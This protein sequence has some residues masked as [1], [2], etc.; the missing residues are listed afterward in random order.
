MKK[1]YFPGV[2]FLIFSSTLTVWAQ[3]PMQ[4]QMKQPVVCYHT[5]EPHMIDVPPPEVYLQWKKNSGARTAANATFEVEY[6]GFDNAPEA[7]AAFDRAFEIWSQ[8]ISSPVPIRVQAEWASLGSNVLGSAIYTSA[9][10]NFDGAQKLNVFYPIALAEKITGLELNDGEPDIFTRFSS[11]TNWNFDPNA[12]PAPDEFDL[13]SVVLHEIGHGLG[14]AGTFSKSGTI[15]EYGLSTTSVPIIFDVP[16]ENGSDVNLI[17]GFANPSASLGTQITGSSLFFDAQLSGTSRLYAPATYSS[18]SSISHLNESTYTTGGD[19]LMTPQIAPGERIHDPGRALSMLKDLGWETIVIEHDRLP[20]TETVSG[21]FPVTVTIRDDSGYDD[22]KISYST[23]DGESFTTVAMTATGNPDE[24]TF[25]IPATGNPTFYRYY[26]TV[27]NGDATYTN[28]GKFVVPQD[29]EI[30][31]SFRFQAGPD[32]ESPVI[33]HSPKAFLLTT[34]SQLELEA[35][36]TDNIEVAS[37]TVAYSINDAAQTPLALSL[38]NPGEDSVYSVTLN[39]GALEEGDV[40]EY[41]IIARDNASAGFNERVSDVFEVNIVGLKETQDSY[42][43][44]FDAVG[45]SDDFFGTGFS[46]TTPAGFNSAAIHSTHP[47]LAGEAFEGDSLVTTYQLKVPIR[48]R[49]TD[50]LIKFEEI[51]LVEPGESGSSFGDPDFYDYVVVEGSLDGGITWEPVANGYDSRA[52]SV[53]FTRFNSA[54]T[55]GSSTATGDPTLYKARQLNLL[56]KYDAGDVVVLRFKLYSDQLATGWGWAIDNL[57][58]QVDETNPVVYNDHVDY[59]LTGAEQLA[60]VTAAE[61]AGG[62][63]SLKVEYRVN[64]GT[65]AE[66]A[67]DVDPPASTYTLNIGLDGFETGDLIEYRIVATDSADLN[68]TF[69]PDGSFIKVPIIEFQSAVSTYTNNFN[70]ATSDFVGNFYSIAQPSGFSNGAI[71]STHNYPVGLGIEK[72]S[73][74]TYTLLKPITIA[75]ANSYIRFDEIAIVETQSASIPFGSPSF[76]DYVIVEGSTDGGET[77]LPF[78]DGYDALRQSNWVSAFTNK[79]DGTSS[80]YRSRAFDMTANGNFDAGDDVIIRFRLFSNTTSAGWGWT[81]DNL[82]IQDFV[83]DAETSLDKAISIHPNPTAE[84]IIINTTGLSSGPVSVQLMN[85]QGNRLQE[86]LYQGNLE[87]E[88][89]SL[90]DLPGGVYF[91]R[92]ASD[93]RTVVRKVVKIN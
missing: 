26:I 88:E 91:V 86:R 56:N 30:Q 22:V 3:K 28:P 50:A 51:V 24:Y 61:D 49:E 52:Q 64:G 16:I 5:N 66:T 20:N 32:T 13:V 74:F 75:A 72:T 93:N 81:I 71:H 6:I 29:D 9:F 77:W 87:N 62:I 31:G 41:T 25:N 23:N 60:I 78:L 14:F 55:D 4:I 69:P 8:L 33:T 7:K 10:A 58:I 73:D 38:Q 79:T 15:G 68:G 12:A 35:R 11:G 92:I 42:A 65:L 2:L 63:K 40:I 57:K 76:N 47:Y 70:T 18:G 1:I 53:W 59:L 34:D 37:V 90:R 82:Y 54:I 80:M 85:A 84:K 45:A 36:V 89:V 44:D 67:F 27:T 19:A 46:I 48:V 17:R 21:T 39:L 43:N 83:T